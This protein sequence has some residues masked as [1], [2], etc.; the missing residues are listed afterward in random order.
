MNY[1]IDGKDF[2]GAY[3]VGVPALQTL[4]YMDGNGNWTGKDNILSKEQFLGNKKVR[5]IEGEDQSFL[6]LDSRQAVMVETADKE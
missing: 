5:K 3:Q 2:I 4:G 6:V 1:G